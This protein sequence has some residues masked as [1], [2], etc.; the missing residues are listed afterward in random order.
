MKSVLAT[1][2]ICYARVTHERDSLTTILLPSNILWPFN[3]GTRPSLSS[4]LVSLSEA[5]L[6]VL[7][8]EIYPVLAP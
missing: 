7:L 5:Q 2:F 3:V 8:K 6:T 4:A 1:D